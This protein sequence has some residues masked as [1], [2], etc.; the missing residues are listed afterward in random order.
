MNAEHL[1]QE[2]VDLLPRLGVLPSQNSPLSKWYEKARILLA[3]QAES[4]QG[5]PK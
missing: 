4:R 3:A 1:L 2:M 5:E